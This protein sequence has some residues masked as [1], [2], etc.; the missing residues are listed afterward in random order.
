MFNIKK[1]I[2]DELSRTDKMPDGLTT[3]FDVTASQMVFN[4]I[5]KKGNAVTFVSNIKDFYQKFGADISETQ[6]GYKISFETAEK[7]QK[8]FNLLQDVYKDGDVESFEREN[9]KQ[10][11][12]QLGLS[13]TEVS[14]I[15]KNFRNK[16]QKEKIFENKEQQSKAPKRKRPPICR[17]CLHEISR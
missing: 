1:Q 13:D 9:L 14:I 16:H 8:Y 6:N 11:Q 17:E 12:H 3:T 7:K 4:E 5:V 10:L 2:F 15:E